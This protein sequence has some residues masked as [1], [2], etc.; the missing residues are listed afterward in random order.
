M[1]AGA[2]DQSH[3]LADFIDIRSLSLREA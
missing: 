2:I 3:K 1:K